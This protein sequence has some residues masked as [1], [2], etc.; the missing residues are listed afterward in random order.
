MVLDETARRA[1]RVPKYTVS[2]QGS[3]FGE[4]YLEWCDDHDVRTR[5]GAIGRHGSIAVEERFI[6][7]L[8]QEGL[9]HE[10]VPLHHGALCASLARFEDWYNDV[11]PHSCMGGATPE[12]FLHRRRPTDRRR[13]FEP[14]ARYRAKGPVRHHGRRRGPRLERDWTLWPRPSGA[15]GTWRKSRSDGASDRCPSDPVFALGDVRLMSKEERRMA[16]FRSLE[17]PKR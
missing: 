14:S 13:R 1:G 8:K 17:P 11:R 15:R 2:G 12:K 16:C 9:E 10:L 4:A 6:R 3:E 5:F 7:T